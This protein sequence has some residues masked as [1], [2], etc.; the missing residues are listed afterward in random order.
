MR[1]LIFAKRNIKEI[2]RDPISYV[3]LLAFPIVMLFVMSAI[4]SGLPP[5]AQVD[6]F[7][8][9][10]LSV[11]IC[12]FG[13]T[14][15]MLFAALHV[16]ADR[17]T[18]FLTRLYSTPM[19]TADFLLGYSIPLLITSIIQCLTIFAL[20]ALPF[21]SSGY[22]ISPVK[23]L[24]AVLTL[25]P[26]ALF[27]I[28]FGTLFG[29]LF[30]NKSAPPLASIIISVSGMLGGIWM[31][32]ELLGSPLSDICKALPFYRCV[33]VGRAALNGRYSDVTASL[34][35][36]SLSAVITFALSIITFQ[37]KKNT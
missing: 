3:F 30:N 26:S 12:V 13:F 33:E 7:K 28:G 6:T 18:A 10:N 15:D 5:E 34:I 23:V 31:D 8:I 36:V 2:I 17:S 20:S 35:Y 27:Y 14:F 11:G 25:I 32:V 22:V 16:S 21:I 4:N 29:S 24:S 37:K 1:P 19:T 9:E